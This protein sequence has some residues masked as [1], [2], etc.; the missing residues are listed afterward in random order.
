MAFYSP[1]RYPGGKGKIANFFHAVMQENDLLDGIYVEP[2]AGGAS[3]ALSLLFNEYV[4]NIVI[5]DL[6]RSIYAFWKSVIYHTHELC[7]LIQK[8]TL[9]MKTWEDCKQVQK[10]KK[11]AK[12]LDLGFSTFFLNRVN[13]SGIITGGIIGG[14]KQ[15][16]KWKMDARFNKQDMIN[17][18]QRIGDYKD[19]IKVSN[20]DAS[21]FLHKSSSLYNSKTLFYLDPPYYENGKKLYVNFYEKKDH[22]LISHRIQAMKKAHWIVSYDNKSE[23]RKLYAKCHH[24][25]YRLNYSAA[26]ATKGNEI[27]FFSNDLNV[28]QSS[29]LILRN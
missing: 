2:Y 15:D 27:M 26:D 11:T 8:A 5:N 20:L 6:D 13:R 16:G 19:R 10:K 1:L 9:N 7:E 23:I 25:Q 29:R 24:I 12:I 14:K 28:S 22:R 17:R 21:Q 3:V 4:S 18:I